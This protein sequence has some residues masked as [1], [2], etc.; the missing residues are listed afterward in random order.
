VHR[1]SGVRSRLSRQRH[2]D[3]EPAGGFAKAP[4]NSSMEHGGGNRVLV[5]GHSGLRENYRSVEYQPPKAGI[6]R[7]SA[8]CELA[9]TSHSWPTVTTATKEHPVGIN[10]PFSYLLP[11]KKPA[12][13]IEEFQARRRARDKSHLPSA[14]SRVG[15]RA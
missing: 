6:S 1:M 12:A 15:S 5:S 2:A 10:A 14:L 9:G 4:R 8:K 11:P 13:L 7:A 3:H